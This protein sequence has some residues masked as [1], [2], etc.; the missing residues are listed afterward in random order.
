MNKKKIYL[1][2][3]PIRSTY[4]ENYKGIIVF[5]GNK[6]FE[7]LKEKNPDATIEK[8]ETIWSDKDKLFTDL[9]L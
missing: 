2:L 1:I 7:Y 4:P 9:I 6:D 3:T 8:I 5:L